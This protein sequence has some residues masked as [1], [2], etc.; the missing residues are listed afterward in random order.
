M[1]VFFRRVKWY[2]STQ[3]CDI[4]V[5][6]LTDSSGHSQQHLLCVLCESATRQCVNLVILRFDLL[7]KIMSV[8]RATANIFTKFALS[9]TFHSGHNKIIKIYAVISMNFLSSRIVLRKAL[10][11]YQHSGTCG[12]GVPDCLWNGARRKYFG[13]ILTKIT[14]KPKTKF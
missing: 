5:S 2:D 7:P 3:H 14:R 11:L 9:I 10:L 12:L 4:T 1:A 8:A 6:N 13:I